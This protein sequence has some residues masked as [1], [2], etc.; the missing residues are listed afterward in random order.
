MPPRALRR[1]SAARP[2][3]SMANTPGRAGWLFPSLHAYSLSRLPRD[4]IAALILTA[5]AVPGQL[6]TSRLMGLPPMVGLFAFAAGALAFAALG[7]NRF[8]SVAADSTIAPI[9][10]GSL[11]LIV[12]PGGAH[13][14]TLAAILALMVGGILLLAGVLRAGWIADL[15]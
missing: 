15:L 9:M 1:R 3:A 2:A 11:A 4:A 10:A 7:A 6:A 12:M 5:I 8:A 14:V 13:Y